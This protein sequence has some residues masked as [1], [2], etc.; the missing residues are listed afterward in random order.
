[1]AGA[2]THHRR[3]RRAWRPHLWRLPHSPGEWPGRHQHGSLDPRVSVDEY[4]AT[5][6]KWFGVG[7]NDLS[8][9]FPNIGHFTSPD[10]G[11]MS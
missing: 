5:L 4:S 11:F 3:R 10:V 8:T 6:A 2:A 7:S 9:V 1:M